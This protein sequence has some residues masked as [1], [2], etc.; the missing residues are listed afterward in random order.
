MATNILDRVEMPTEEKDESEED[1]ESEEEIETPDPE[2]DLSRVVLDKNQ[3]EEIKIVTADEII[4]EVVEDNTKLS[5]ADS[6]FFT[7]SMDLS[8]EDFVMDTDFQEKKMPLALKIF[9]AILVIAALAVTGYFIWKNF[10]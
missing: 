4:I 10:S 8:N 5:G 2:L 7:K 9:L 6:D 1:D 3:L